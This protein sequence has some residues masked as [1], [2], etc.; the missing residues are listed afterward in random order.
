MFERFR[1]NRARAADSA[2]QDTPPSGTTAVMDR[3]EAPATDTGEHTAVHDRPATAPAATD[4]F[5]DRREAQRAEFGGLDWP[6]A[7]FGWLVAIGIATLLV[8]VLGAAGAALGITEMGSTSDV[9]A[10]ADTIGVAGGVLLLVALLIAYYAGG[11]V[12][13]R[14]AR[15]DGLRQGVAVWFIALAV[16]VLLALAGLVLG[17]EYNVFEQ[18]DLPRIPVDEG[19]VTT[20]GIIALAA[21]AV[22][23]LLA[24]VLGG[25]SGERYHRRIDRF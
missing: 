6:A 4:A 16:T 13:G 11:Y 12:A 25:R 24:A 5:A 18:L 20:G 14:M 3:P 10:K 8:A 2:R 1:P 9:A 17:S 15:F 7:F 23:T 21:V 19:T 22:G